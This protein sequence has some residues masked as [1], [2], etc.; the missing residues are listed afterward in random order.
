MI[1]E[2]FNDIA[3]IEDDQFPEKMAA[4]VKEPGFEHAVRW[5]LPDIDY[6]TFAAH[7]ASIKAKRSCN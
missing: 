6:D 1:K 7:F 2:E 5:V 4:L 3:P